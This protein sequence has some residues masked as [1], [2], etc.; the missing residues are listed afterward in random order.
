MTT[1]VITAPDGQEYEIEAPEGATEAQ[2]L[3]YFQQNWKPETKKAKSLSEMM[4]TPAETG[5]AMTRGARGLAEAG[6]QMLTGIPAAAIGGLRG[7]GGLATGESGEEATA[8]AQALQRG[9][10]YEPRLEEG[11]IAAE[12]AAMP[13]EL[14]GKAAGWAGSQSEIAR[15]LGPK[16]QAAAETI[17]EVTP[18]IA[19]TLY[20]GRAALRGAE[21]KPPT[22]VPQAIKDVARTRTKAGQIK[23]AEEY[24]KKMTTPEEAAKVVSALERRGEPIVPGSPVTSADAIARANREMALKGQPERFGG[25]Y[26]ALQ[27]GLSAVPET[28]AGLRTVQ[29]QQEAARAGILQRGAGTEAQRL[30]LEQTRRANAAANYQKLA[31]SKAVVEVSKTANLIDRIKS[32]KPGN[33]ALVSSM[34]D[35]KS[36]LVE[37]DPVTGSHTLR[38]NPGQLQS[39]IEN[40]NNLLAQKENVPVRRQLMVVKKSLENQINK[41][42]SIQG[43]ATKQYAIDSLPLNQMDLWSAMKDK[44]I[45]PTGKEAPGSYLRALRDET[46]LIKEA[47]GFKRGTG[48]DKIFNKEQSALAARLAA[49]MEMEIVK[50]RM[51]SEVNLPGVGKAAQAIEPQLPNM[52]MR[53][54]MVANFIL[55]TLAKNANVDV[56]IAAANILKDPKALAG[57]LKQVKVDNRPGVLK[58]IRKAS[59]SKGA[60]ITGT[61]LMEEE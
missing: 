22:I 31:E 29:L 18:A 49:E 53:E 55:R 28:T 23:L 1:Y 20:G 52:L 10:T 37:I 7:L 61:A 45:S 38:T 6:A 36:S 41:V 13:M 4:P 46:K 51:A 33:K 17:G 32:A 56:N 16:A 44:F 54:T 60:A 42:E 57:V 39:S 9:L 3:A 12:I 59:T 30:A 2:A 47:T 5:A 19:G 35:V 26:V 48:V 50:K 58:A 24:L 34:D 21:V 43:Q 40:I 27:E 25:Q 14:A 15:L 8:A 11:Q